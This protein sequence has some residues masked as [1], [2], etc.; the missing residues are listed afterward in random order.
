ML[1]FIP[2]KFPCCESSLCEPLKTI[3]TFKILSVVM[4]YLSPLIF[5][6]IVFIFNTVSSRHMD[7]QVVFNKQLPA[8][9]M[10]ANTRHYF[11]CHK[12]FFNI[13]LIF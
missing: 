1:S 8:I 9:S 11:Y 12:I 4:A 3:P 2:D 10:K 13:L 7:A 5:E 6:L